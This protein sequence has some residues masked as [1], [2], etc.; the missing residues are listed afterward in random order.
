MTLLIAIV[1]APVVLRIITLSELL[2][3][4]RLMLVVLVA[5]V[6]SVLQ[7]A[8][9]VTCGFVFPCVVSVLTAMVV[10]STGVLG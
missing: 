8:T 3:S 7:V 10:L 2:I 9:V 5:V 4:S 6:R 1:S